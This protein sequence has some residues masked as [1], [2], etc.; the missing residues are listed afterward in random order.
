MGLRIRSEKRVLVGQGI[1]TTIFVPKSTCAD[2]ALITVGRITK[3]KNLH[4]LIRIL[5]S[6]RKIRSDV[7]LTFVGNIGNSDDQEYLNVLQAEAIQLGVDNS[8]IWHGGVKQ[9]ELP[10]LLARAQVFVTTAQNGS[11]DKAI[12][13]AMA[14]GLPVVS[15]ASG[16]ITLPLGVDQCTSSEDCV[17]RILYYLHTGIEI[18][19]QYTDYV[20]TQ[21]SLAQLIPKILNHF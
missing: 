14:V 11:L 5:A 2:F 21:H 13:E 6:V 4:T 18:L 16:S 9:T 1:D 10:A 3:A 17:E 7:T 15:L 20:R 12:L 8:I 19:P